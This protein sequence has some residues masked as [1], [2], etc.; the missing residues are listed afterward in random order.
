MAGITSSPVW[1]DLQLGAGELGSCEGV[2][3]KGRRG[4]AMLRAA[5]G[6]I[7]LSIAAV[8]GEM[9]G[10]KDLYFDDLTWTIR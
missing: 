8:D 10:I 6:F 5:S 3:V 9:G 1:Q 2:Q 7:G 4:R